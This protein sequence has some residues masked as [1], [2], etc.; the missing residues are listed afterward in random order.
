[1][2]NF[3]YADRFFNVT[4]K[5]RAYGGAMRPGLYTQKT[6]NVARNGGSGACGGAYLRFATGAYRI[7]VYGKGL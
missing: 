2:Y 6:Q 7:G 1:M 3:V 4:Y 5:R